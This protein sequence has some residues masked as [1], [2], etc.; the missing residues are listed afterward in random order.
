MA[1]PKLDPK[2]LELL[3]QTDVGAQRIAKVYA[4]ALLESAEKAGQ[5]QEVLEQFR[6]LVT[7][8]LQADP[9]L[10]ALFTSGAIGRDARRHALEKAFKDRANP[11]LY[12]FLQVVNDHERLDLVREMLTA[13][14]DLDNE[15]NRRVQVTVSTAV[16]LGG[17]FRE[18]IAN[19]VRDQFRLE[20][21]LVEK[22]EPDLLG[23]MK[24]QIGDVVYDST[25]R[26]RIDTLK[27]QLLARSSH[28]IQSG[29]DR[30]SIDAGN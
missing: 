10:A 23:G 30:I 25:I 5:V 8:V 21:V 27:Q 7:D 2:L 19:R 4:Q 26:T 14:L 9:R 18:R 12:H 24:L 20:P 3:K 1:D 17:D 11:V 15:R 16:P 13:A 6:S 29:R 22:I 28:E